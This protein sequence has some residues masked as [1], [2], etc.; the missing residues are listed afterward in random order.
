VRECSNTSSVLKTIHRVDMEKDSWARE[1][2]GL[3]PDLFRTGEMKKKKVDQKKKGK[4]AL[5]R[6]VA[7]TELTALGKKKRVGDRPQF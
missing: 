2:E 1:K 4:G 5:Q 3:R 7:E 6:K